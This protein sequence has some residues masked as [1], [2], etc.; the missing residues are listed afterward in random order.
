MEKDADELWKLLR[1][2]VRTIGP[3]KVLRRLGPSGWLDDAIPQVVEEWGAERVLKRLRIG[4]QPIDKD[5]AA[6]EALAAVATSGKRLSRSTREVADRVALDLLDA[7]AK[8]PE[9]NPGATVAGSVVEVIGT[10]VASMAIDGS[11][12]GL[13]AWRVGKRIFVTGYDVGAVA[14][15]K[16]LHDLIAWWIRGWGEYA[17]ITGSGLN[18]SVIRALGLVRSDDDD[19][20]DGSV[21]INGRIW[22]RQIA[23]A[24]T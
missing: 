4:E 10:K 24:E 2:T 5:R 18:A 23:S 21:R 14:V 15:S 7:C 19:W 1:P 8:L 6:G 20:V 13:E 22:R 9:D 16:D 17:E 12:H 11:E 3:L